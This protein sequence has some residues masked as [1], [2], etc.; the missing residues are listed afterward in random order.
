M[1]NEQPAM[2][3]QLTYKIKKSIRNVESITYC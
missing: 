2:F 1:V 3:F